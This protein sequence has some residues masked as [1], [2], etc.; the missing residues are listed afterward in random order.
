MHENSEWTLWKFVLDV[1]KSEKT[2]AFI[3]VVAHEK[4]SPGKTGFKMAITAEK[5]STGTIGGGI[6]EFSIKEQYALQ[7]REGKKISDVRKLVHTQS[8]KRGEPSGLTCAGSQTICAVSLSEWDI[9][10]VTSI[11]TSLTDNL[12][13]TLTITVNGIACREGKQQPQTTFEQLSAFGWAYFENVGPEYALYI[14]GGGHVGAALAR[15]VV[16]LN[17][18]VV[19]YDDREPIKL[20]GAQC[21]DQ[22]KVT[23]SYMRLAFHITD[24]LHSFAAIVTSDVSTDTI[25]L[26]QL[27]PL[28][29]P[30][31]GIMGVEAKI[32]RIKNSLS[33]E[34]VREFEQQYIHAPIGIRIDSNTAEEIAVSIAAE[35]ISVRNNLRQSYT[36]SVSE[37]A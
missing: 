32:A 15:I 17:F 8:S 30:Y 6:M 7:L 3:A 24:P 20:P 22:K 34:E 11:L 1:L 25:A 35:I 16:G 29:L 4:G 26:K 36:R 9:P 28:R 31:V 37:N 10:T 12:P 23:D 33:I 19:V 13:A 14:V 21:V 5:R 27:L 2:V 18:Y